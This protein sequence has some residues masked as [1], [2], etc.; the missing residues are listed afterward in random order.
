MRRSI[1]IASII[2]GVMIAGTFV[3]TAEAAR[4]IQTLW[5]Q[6]FLIANRLAFWDSFLDKQI[7]NLN[8]EQP[9]STIHSQMERI[10]QNAESIDSKLT[11]Y[12]GER[13]K[14][15]T[16]INK[17]TLEEHN[18]VNVD[19]GHSDIARESSVIGS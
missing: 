9:S 19:F 16:I 8:G 3:S 11:P 2:V 18:A 12:L 6:F 13:P 1:L 7:A 14:P 10:R 5:G 17:D 15:T 4:P